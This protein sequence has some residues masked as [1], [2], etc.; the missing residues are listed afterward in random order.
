MAT[1]DD[2]RLPAPAPE[3]PAPE[4]P[5]SEDPAPDDPAPG[6]RAPGAAG[7]RAR[8]PAPGAPADASAPPAGAPDPLL[9]HVLAQLAWYGRS[10]ARARRTHRAVELALLTTTSATVVAS[11]LSA[12][13][14]ATAAVAAGSVFL[15]GLRQLLGPGERWASAGVAWQELQQAVVRYRLLPEAE[16]DAAA[17]EALLARAEEVALNETRLWAEGRRAALPGPGAGGSPAG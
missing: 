2:R 10:R 16:R 3:D 14:F 17:R 12:P 1:Q 9:D 11:A 4:D 15:T 6:A 13:A 7:A 5:V 8:V